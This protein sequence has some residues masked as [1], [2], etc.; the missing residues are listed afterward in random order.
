LQY[1][2]FRQVPVTR[3]SLHFEFPTALQFAK[4]NKLHGEGAVVA[5]IENERWVWKEVVFVM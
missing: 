4:L 2:G 1:V 5:N 3:S